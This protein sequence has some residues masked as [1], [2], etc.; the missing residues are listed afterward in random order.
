MEGFGGTRRRSAAPLTATARWWWLPGL[1]LCF[2]ALLWVRPA[3][4]ESVTLN[5]KD[6]DIGAL[7]GTV[8]QITGKNFVVDP[9]VKGKVTVISSHAMSSDEVYQVFLSILQVHGFAAVPSGKVIKIVPDINAK[10]DAIPTATARHPGKGDQ[11]VTRVVQ[12]SNVSAAQLVPIL[13][14]LVPQQGHLAAYPASNVLI[15]SDRADNVERLVKIIHSIDSVK[16]NEIDVV[17]LKHA[18]ATDVAHILTSL[19]H[20]EASRGKTPGGAGPTIIADERTNSVLIGGDR[21][22][23]LRLRAIVEELDSPQAQGGTTHVIHLKY[24]KAKDL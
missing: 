5:L 21:A 16:D 4:A 10:Q 17:P 18:S 24:A 15:I 8:S 9:R 19:A 3:A 1:L 6:A 22:E 13:R 11:M 20:S 14:P 7:I 12:V 2:A 23:R